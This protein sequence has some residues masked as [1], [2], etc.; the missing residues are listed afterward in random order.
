MWAGVQ[1]SYCQRGLKVGENAA[2]A[3]AEAGSTKDGFAEGR[4]NTE[5][6]QKMQCTC[7]VEM[8]LVLYVCL[9]FILF[10]I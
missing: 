1:G 10:P 7:W 5:L 6:L 9:V 8:T 4:A 2:H 3:P